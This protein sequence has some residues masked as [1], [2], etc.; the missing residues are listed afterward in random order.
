MFFQTLLIFAL[1]QMAQSC[2]S[3][4]CSFNQ[5]RLT[6]TVFMCCNGLLSL[7]AI[8]ETHIFRAGKISEQTCVM[9]NLAKN[10]LWSVGQSIISGWRL[11]RDFLANSASVPFT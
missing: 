3:C 11:K 5:S 4:T 7:F 2:T 1:A 10:Q 6:L 9:L 8:Y